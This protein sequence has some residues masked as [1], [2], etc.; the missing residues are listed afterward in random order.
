MRMIGGIKMLILDDAENPWE[1]KYGRGYFDKIWYFLFIN[2][3]NNSQNKRNNFRISA[4][5][6]TA[7]LY[8]DGTEEEG[9]TFG[10]SG[11]QRSCMGRG[12]VRDT[13]GK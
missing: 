5:I 3:T 1:G 8:V 10:E 6:E 12:C 13:Q 7:G 9:K 2:A 4:S 11:Y